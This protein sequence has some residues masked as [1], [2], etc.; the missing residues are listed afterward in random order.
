AESL[1]QHGYLGEIPIAFFRAQRAAREGLVARQKAG[2]LGGMHPRE[3]VGVVRA[4]GASV[5]SGAVY[6]RM[7]ATH[8]GD[9]RLR[10]E[11][12]AERRRRDVP[13]GLAQPAEWIL[14]VVGVLGH[15][16]HRERVQGLE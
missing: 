11:P 6:V 14:T 5:G 15:A 2:H 8:L 7:R 9:C 16:R 4:V 3:Q 10:L 12:W 13:R 1:S